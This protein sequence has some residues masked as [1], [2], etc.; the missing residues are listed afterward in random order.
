M[1]DWDELVVVA[2]DPQLG[3]PFMKEMVKQMR[4]IDSYGL[5]DKAGDHEILDPFVLTKERKQQVPI[6][7]DPD[8]AVIGRVKAWYNALSST[9]EQRTGMMAIPLVHLSHEGFGRAIIAVG[10]LIVAD[11]SLRDVHRFGFRSLEEMGQEAEK[12]V[13]KAAGLIEAHRAVAEL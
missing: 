8:E 1:S 6:V 10:K 12:V 13:T 7:G 11:R 3:S 5:W 4:A 2:D 9:I